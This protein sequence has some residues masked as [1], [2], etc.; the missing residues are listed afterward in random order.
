MGSDTCLHDS[1]CS[2]ATRGLPDAKRPVAGILQPIFV[3]ASDRFYPLWKEEQE[4]DQRKPLEQDPQQDEKRS[5]RSD[6][7]FLLPF[8]I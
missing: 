8:F 6:L 1:S 3:G 7:A 4:V 5:L 2:G